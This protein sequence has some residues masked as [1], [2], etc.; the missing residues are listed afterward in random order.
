MS[1]WEDLS[2]YLDARERSD[3]EAPDPWADVEL[4]D[5]SLT[6]EQVAFLAF[7]Q[8]PMPRLGG[9]GTDPESSGD[10]EPGGGTGKTPGDG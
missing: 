5:S 4:G 1:W 2:A 3:G 9:L 10:A 7:D 8:P 6:E